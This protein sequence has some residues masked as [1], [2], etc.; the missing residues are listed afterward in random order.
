MHNTLLEEKES[1]HIEF[2]S[3]VPKFETLIKTCI[4]FANAAG[5]RIF[6]GVEDSTHEVIGI[7][8]ED[9]LK[10]YNDFPNSLYDS[11]TPSLIAQIYEQNINMKSVLIIEIPPSPKKP[12]FLKSKG[13]KDGT[14]IRVGSSTR[15]AT[16]ET[17]EDLTREA[18]RI[19]YDEEL[20]HADLSILSKELLHHFFWCTRFQKTIAR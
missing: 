18:Q 10:I 8:D 2:K 7:S 3:I 12:Y 4:A 16:T 17:I 9:R 19:S 14:Y 20:V 1:K 15:L 13:V 6:I 5:G 11:T